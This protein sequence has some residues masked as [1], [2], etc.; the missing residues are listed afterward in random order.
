[1]NI[2]CAMLVSTPQTMST[3]DLRKS[4]D[5]YKRYKIPILGCV[6]NFSGF[7]CGFCK[8]K[9]EIFKSPEFDNIL[10]SQN[11]PLLAS[12]PIDQTISLPGD[13]GYPIVV[14]EPDH[15][16]SKKFYLIADEIE[17]KFPKKGT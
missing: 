17:K 10:K 13:E 15:E 5:L 9:T 8:T 14:R 12:I 16:I 11:I 7:Q 1:M 6:K 4:I 2:D 3:N